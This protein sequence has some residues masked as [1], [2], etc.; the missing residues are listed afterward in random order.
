MAEKSKGKCDESQ[1]RILDVKE[2]AK[3][4]EEED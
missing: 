3:H 1:C 2:L 4:N